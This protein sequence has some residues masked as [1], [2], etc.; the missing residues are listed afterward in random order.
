M[1]AH[2]NFRGEDY[3]SALLLRMVMDHCAT[4]NDGELSSF[5]IEIHADAL[6]ALAESGLIEIIERDGAQIRAKVLPAA[7]EL[8]TRFL[9]DRNTKL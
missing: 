6:Q 7:D 5:A 8:V 4:M 1:T 2:Q 9:S 3:L